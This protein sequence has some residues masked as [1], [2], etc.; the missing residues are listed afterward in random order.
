MTVVTPELLLQ[1]YRSGVFPMAEHRDDPEI[2]WVDPRRRGVFP[3]NGF[4]ISRSLARVVRRDTFSVTLNRDFAG[5]IDG[6][7]DRPETWINGEIRALYLDLFAR[8]DAHSLEV[9]QDGRLA[10]GVYGVTQG[11]AFFGESMFSRRTDASKVALAWL[12][13]HLNRCG[14]RLF[15]TQFLTPHLASLGAVEIS[16]ALYRAQLTDALHHD[17]DFTASPLPGS[18]HEVVQANAQIS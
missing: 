5:V 18:G 4:H 11:A 9:W 13:V 2:F 14:F 16:R 6:C 7:A 3:L 15:D 10:G 17:A 1:A 8:G 12:V